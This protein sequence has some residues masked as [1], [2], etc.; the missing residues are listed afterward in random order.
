[1]GSNHIEVRA[2]IPDGGFLAGWL[3]YA[4]PFEAADSYFLFSLLA[5]ASCA[6]NR[7]VLVNPGSEPEV[8]TNLHVLVVGPSGARKASIK[9]AIRLLG[10]AVPEAPVL[11]SSFSMEALC[12]RL[13]KESEE[14]GKGAGLIVSHEFARLIGGSD[15]AE[16]NLGFLCEIWDCPDVYTRETFAHGYEELHNAYV[17]VLGAVQPDWLEDLETRVLKSGPLRRILG[18]VEYG[19][20][21]YNSHPV[22]NTVLFNRLKDLM[23]ARLG[24]GAFGPT[25]VRLSDEAWALKAKWYEETVQPKWKGAGEIEGHFVSCMEAQA[26]KLAT[27]VAFLEGGPT[28]T[29]HVGS[30]RIG[31]ALVEAIVPNLFQLYAGLVSGPFGKLRSAIRRTLMLAGGEMGEARLDEAVMDSTGAKPGDILLAKQSLISQGRIIRE[32]GKVKIR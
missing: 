24:P 12:T 8:Y 4:K 1:M 27:I 22:A 6:I 15:Y 28:D 23:R 13:A 25:F 18:V 29:L 16:R 10:E 26:L 5:A 31:Q 17:S 14:I 2:C 3:E 11:P 9:H 7:R 32:G 30:L 20:K 21:H 19:V